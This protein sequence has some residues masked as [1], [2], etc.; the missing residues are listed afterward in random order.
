MPSKLLGLAVTLT[1]PTLLAAQTP[2]IPNQH[3][4]D[5]GA[6]MVTLHSQGA[7]H[8]A[9]HRRGEVVPVDHTRNRNAA[10]PAVRATP[11]VP[12]HDVVPTL[13]T[14]RATPAIPA[15][16]GGQSGNHRP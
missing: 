6:A 5:R 1:L 10:T 3:A 7:Q 14:K 11:T 13:P 16:K 2:E 9:T 15:H 8:R 4:S 12:G